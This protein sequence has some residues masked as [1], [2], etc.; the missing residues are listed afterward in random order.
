M[1]KRP[2]KPAIEAAATHLRAIS[3]AAEDGAFIGSEEALLQILGFSRSTVRQVAR[4]LEQEGLLRVKRGIGG[5]YY[6]ARP[7]ARTIERVVSSYLE[8]VDFEREEVTIIASALW[9]EVVRKA[10]LMRNQTS[11]DLAE[12]FRKRVL[13]MKPNASFTEIRTMEM[14]SRRAIF[15]LVQT[16]YIELIFDIN[17][18]FASRSFPSHSLA[19]NNEE[20][21]AFVKQW[22]EAKLLELAAIGD[23]NVE[24]GRMAARYIRSVWHKR[25]WLPKPPAEVD[26]DGLEDHV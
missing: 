3:M 16:R 10:T 8:S 13:A 24:L 22:R 11:R 18:A 7:D 4:L 12:S 21:V 9:V 14:E 6:A 26:L 1:D 5:G 17:I 25:I 2:S 23:G 19:D 15:D 20:H